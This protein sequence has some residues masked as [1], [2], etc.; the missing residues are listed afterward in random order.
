M[1]LVCPSLKDLPSLVTKR[2]PSSKR[3]QVL[4]KSTHGGLVH[5]SRIP[6]FL[7]HAIQQIHS[8]VAVSSSA[9]SRQLHFPP[10][11]SKHADCC[12]LIADSFVKVTLLHS[13]LV[14]V[15]NLRYGEDWR[16]SRDTKNPRATAACSG[17][18]HKRWPCLASAVPSSAPLCSRN[19]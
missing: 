5:T 7:W 4:L 15:P 13:A 19:V 9:F 14:Q 3:N 11:G 10:F 16:Q 1:M 12:L 6:Y 18:L 17:S 8:S 2:V